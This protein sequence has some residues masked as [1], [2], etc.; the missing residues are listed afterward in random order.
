M[1]ANTRGL[2]VG[3]TLLP[4]RN[5]WTPAGGLGTVSSGV[6]LRY[7]VCG[8]VSRRKHFVEAQTDLSVR[9]NTRVAAAALGHAEASDQH[10]RRSSS[11]RDASE[12]QKSE[13]RHRARAETSPGNGYPA[14]TASR[15]SAE[16]SGFMEEVPASLFLCTNIALIVT[17]G[18]L[19]LA[20]VHAIVFLL[21]GSPCP[22]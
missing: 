2:L 13:S 3:P 15:N 12:A 17:P 9:A 19:S 20:S 21:P 4:V 10:R 11:S 5:F 18:Q 1:Q 8:G 16:R 7:C 14:P 6:C 22:P